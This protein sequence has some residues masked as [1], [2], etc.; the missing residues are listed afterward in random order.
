MQIETTTL[1]VQFV[2][3]DTGTALTTTSLTATPMTDAQATSTGETVTASTDG[4]GLVRLSFPSRYPWLRI[5]TRATSAAPATFKL[6]TH[7]SYFDR[8]KEPTADEPLRLEIKRL[9]ELSGTVYTTDAGQ[10]QPVPVPG[11]EVILSTSTRNR[12]DPFSEVSPREIE[13]TTTVAD[14]SGHYR[15]HRVPHTFFHLSART[16]KRVAAGCDIVLKSNE[17][18]G[19]FD[20]T[21][22]PGFSLTLLVNDR[23]TLKPIPEATVH[24]QY[25]DTGLAIVA[26]TTAEGFADLSPLPSGSVSL[27]VLA[28]GYLMEKTTTDITGSLN[29]IT[30][31]SLTKG[32]TARIRTVDGHNTP[33]PNTRVSLNWE[34]VSESR[35]AQT[36]EKGEARLTELP[37][38]TVIEISGENTDPKVRPRFFLLEGE[39]KEVTFVVTK[40]APPALSASSKYLRYNLGWV[41]GKVVDPS[42]RPVAGATIESTLGGN[43]LTDQNGGFRLENLKFWELPIETKQLL[44]NQGEKKNLVYI[45]M[46]ISVRAKGYLS[47]FVGYDS[48]MEKRIV[49]HPRNDMKGHVLD[50]E[51]NQPIRLFDLACSSSIT[52]GES[53]KRFLSETGEFT[54]SDR[55]RSIKVLADGYLPEVVRL[56]GNDESGNPSLQIFPK[57]GEY[58]KGRVVD[59]KTGDP[60]KGV[61]VGYSKR[62]TEEGFM[63]ALQFNDTRLNAEYVEVTNEEGEFDF[64]R[65]FGE[66]GGLGFF[67]ADLEEQRAAL[68]TIERFRD[69]K[70]GRL[71][72]PMN[73]SKPGGIV[74][75]EWYENGVPALCPVDAPPPRF[76]FGPP[77]ENPISLSKI[78]YGDFKPGRLLIGLND[79]GFS[80]ANGVF[81]WENLKPGEYV[82]RLPRPSGEE[83]EKPDSLT[84]VFTLESQAVKT[85]RWGNGHACSLSG[86][87]LNAQNEPYPQVCL[88]LTH[89]SSDRE[90]SPDTSLEE[91]MT[92]P[93]GSYRID[94]L[95]PGE[96]A[97]VIAEPPSAEG[98]SG[99]VL[100]SNETLQVDGATKRDFTILSQQAR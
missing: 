1:A 26:R 38:N 62:F 82:L 43:T 88:R 54:L 29:D 53:R 73:S 34:S 16:D 9:H 71:V 86:R 87:V 76:S 17:T 94:C 37:L 89:R 21:L 51:T 66:E 15:F 75:L 81:R 13:T 40:E 98:E 41:A 8:S 47:A 46:H 5:D 84:H 14:A 99:K 100:L 90:I 33:V 68:E 96:Y 69:R 57:K 31:F 25:E 91:V 45:P 78:L 77:P 65:V 22:E 32:G 74:V 35:T 58:L 36:D 50:K 20:L 27:K 28:D 59:E 85:I 24:A 48:G 42:N 67:R 49:L 97:L 55:A 52:G 56:S 6:D 10:A 19:P 72:I 60:L 4:K 30:L 70:T 12:Y 79:P 80:Y 93:D 95:F 44:A 64:K 7:D 23:K 39:E 61:L 83:K 18:S 63:G 2:W 11:A 92:T 3:N